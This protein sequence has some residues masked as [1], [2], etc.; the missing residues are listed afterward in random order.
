[1]IE[2]GGHM[3]CPPVWIPLNFYGVCLDNSRDLGF[4]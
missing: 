3:F 4:H 2:P 1:L